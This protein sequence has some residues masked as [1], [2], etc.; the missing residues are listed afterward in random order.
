M[1]TEEKRDSSADAGL[2]ALWFGLFAGPAA[3]LLNLQ[4]AY[5]LAPQ[6]C[7][8]GSSDGHPTGPAPRQP[9]GVGRNQVLTRQPVPMHPAQRLAVHRDRIAGLDPHRGQP[10]PDGPLER[11]SIRS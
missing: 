8:T 10:R 6:T 1:R 3:F 2:A 7:R 11:G 5:M 9:G 4:I